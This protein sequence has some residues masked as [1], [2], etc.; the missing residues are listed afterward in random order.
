[1]AAEHTPAMVS[2]NP[3]ER[4]VMQV[5]SYPPNGRS[6][7]YC[8]LRSYKAEPGWYSVSIGPD[9][10][11]WRSIVHVFC[12][13]VFGVANFARGALAGDA[14]QSVRGVD[15]SGVELLGLN[16]DLEPCHGELG[17]GLWH[18][19]GHRYEPG[20]GQPELPSEM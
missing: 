6:F 14:S 9:G 1:M 8:V 11:E 20:G 7:E 17:C 19:I 18:F 5:E 2:Q 10:R 15:G 3:S 4:Q 16:E 12:E 13:V